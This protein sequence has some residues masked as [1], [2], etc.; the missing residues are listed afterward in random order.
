MERIRVKIVGDPDHRYHLLVG[1]DEDWTEMPVSDIDV[2][3]R[4]GQPRRAIVTFFDPAVEITHAV[5]VDD[6]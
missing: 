4:P 6:G 1:T 3:L 5:G 2:Q